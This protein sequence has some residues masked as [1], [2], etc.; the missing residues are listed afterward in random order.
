M[1]YNFND[2]FSARYL[3][4]PL[5]KQKYNIPLVFISIDEF[6]FKNKW[7]ND[8]YHLNLKGYHF[9]VNDSLMKDI[10]EK[11]YNNQSLIIP[12][13]VYIDKKGEI[14]TNDAPRPSSIKALDKLF[15]DL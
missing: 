4:L 9:L 14:I 10:K 1:I 12:R 2:K 6:Q 13:Y 7:I 15:H 5:K 8:I 3:Q 11:I